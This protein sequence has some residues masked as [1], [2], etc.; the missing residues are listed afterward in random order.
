MREKPVLVVPTGLMRGHDIIRK[1]ILNFLNSHDLTIKVVSR[2]FSV[3]L[4]LANI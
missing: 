3:G 4:A 2:E 1:H